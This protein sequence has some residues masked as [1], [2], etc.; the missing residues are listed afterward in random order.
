MDKHFRAKADHYLLHAA[1][2][3]ELA[4]TIDNE[5]RRALLYSVADELDDLAEYYE[6]FANE[7]HEQLH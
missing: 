2:L 4:V 5:F 7:W 3:R 1:A 6:S